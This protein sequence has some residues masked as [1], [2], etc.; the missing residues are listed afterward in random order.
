M[1]PFYRVERARPEH[2][3]LAAALAGRLVRLH[4]E[5]DPA[6]F[7]LPEQV[8]AGYAAWFGREVARRDAVVL[9]GLREQTVVGYAYG[10]VEGRDWNL[11]LDRH[12]AIHDVFVTEAERR[13]GLGRRLIEVMITELEQLGAPRIVLSTMV[14][15]TAAQALFRACGFRATM[16]EMTRG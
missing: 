4:H 3:P 6:R 14:D 16:L 1:D 11:L 8:E 9:V 15:N 7:F 12:G 2:V 5:K 10:A 13:S